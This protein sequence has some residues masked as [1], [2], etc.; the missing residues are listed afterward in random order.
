MVFASPIFLFC[1]LPLVLCLAFV[2]PSRLRNLVLLLVSLV[3]YAWGETKFLPLVLGLV[4]I[5]W[6]FGLLIDATESDRRRKFI[7]T[8]S[9]VVTMSALI[10]FKYADFVVDNF[11]VALST[12]GIS[13]LAQPHIAL[14]LG[15]SFFSFHL[16]SYVIDIYRG[17]AKSQRNPI[18]FGLYI[19]FF[20]QLIAGP[21]IRYHDVQ[22]Q[23]TKR[24]VTSE[25]IASGLERFVLGMTKKIVVANP[26]GQVADR[27]FVLSSDDLSTTVAWLGLAC[28]AFQLYFDFSGYSDI[29]IGLGRIFGFE[30]LENFNYPFVS[31][32]I[33]EF[34]RRWHISLSNWFRDYLY[35]P[36]V[37]HAA[38]KNPQEKWLAKDQFDD[39]LQLATVFLLCGIWHGASW[40]FVVWGGIHG[41]FLAL[42]RGRFGDIVRGLPA[43]FAHIYV[44]AVIL[45]AWVFF[46]ADTLTHAFAFLHAMVGHSGST[47]EIWPVAAFVDRRVWILLFVSVIGATPAFSWLARDWRQRAAQSF[48]Q[49]GAN[50]ADR[51]AGVEAILRMVRPPIL[52]AM[53]VLSACFI[54]GE[55]YNPFI[56]FR[57]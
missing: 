16:L 33:S 49:I 22:D 32:S 15:I 39:K 14:P 12:V 27:I 18:D 53:F 42:E 52:L 1:F 23:L 37:M 3:F 2:T 41:I 20:P 34:W 51:S 5:N 43:P 48:G 45:S 8:C 56:Y 54:A 26:L 55:T 40:T 35:L 46:R 44:L 57:F 13:P 19:T 28:Y 38:R 21:I 36:L 29:A 11:N 17:V 25:K 24:I 47:S 9:V 31:R 30:Y 7:V 4:V 50:P 10:I 6:I